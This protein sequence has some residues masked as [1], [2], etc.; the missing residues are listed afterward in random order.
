MAEPN[1]FCIID[2]YLTN[3]TYTVQHCGYVSI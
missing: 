3:D 1:Q 2:Q